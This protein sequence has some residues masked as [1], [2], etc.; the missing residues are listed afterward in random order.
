MPKKKK[1]AATIPAYQRDTER[2][3]TRKYVTSSGL[4]VVLSGLPPLVPQRVDA[5]VEYP[6]KPTYEVETASGDI[7]VYEHDEESLDTDESRAEW[8]AYEEALQEAETQLTEKLLYAVL[9]NS[10]ELEDYEDKFATWKHQQKL[11][12]LPLAEPED[13]ENETSVRLA[14]EENKF[15]FMQSE[16]F[17]DADDI[18]EILTVVM[19][20]TGV[21]VEDLASA[22]DSFPGEMESEPPEG[23]GDIAGSA[24]DIG[25]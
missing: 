18:G 2:E 15:Y 5:S 25:E 12:Q 14:E 8:K 9:V 16:V 10:V 11:Q 4:E 3:R 19:G 13:P 21:S 17:H 22:R 6:D 1:R 23:S 20:L 7:E 24:E